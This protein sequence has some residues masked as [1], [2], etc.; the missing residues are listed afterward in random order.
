M[1][2]QHKA[3]NAAKYTPLG[4]VPQPEQP[5][6]KAPPQKVHF[7]TKDAVRRFKAHAMMEEKNH[8]DVVRVGLRDSFWTDIYHHALTA[9]WGTFAGFAVIFYLAVNRSLIHI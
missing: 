4:D 3:R 8:D 9:S 2:D 5:A 7:T 1:K 6:P